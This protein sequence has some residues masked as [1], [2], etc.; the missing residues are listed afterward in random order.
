MYIERWPCI[1]RKCFDTSCLLAFQHFCF[2]KPTPIPPLLLLPPMHPALIAVRKRDA[3]LSF[4]GKVVKVK[5]V[6]PWPQVAN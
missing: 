2:H 4:T 5:V 6:K 1:Y 3:L